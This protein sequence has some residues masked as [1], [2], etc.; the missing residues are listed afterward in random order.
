M[1]VNKHQN[2]KNFFWCIA[3]TSQ[4]KQFNPFKKTASN[5]LYVAKYEQ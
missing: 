1:F 3:I 2:Y 5:Q 4:N